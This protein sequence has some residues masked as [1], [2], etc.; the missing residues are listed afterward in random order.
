MEGNPTPDFLAL[1]REVRPE[2][3]TLV[4]DAPDAITSNAGW[5]VV[6]HQR[7]FARGSSRAESCRRPR[8]HFPR[9]LTRP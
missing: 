5:D 7:L 6:G 8:Q 1:C 3:V 2:Q 9:T 4:P